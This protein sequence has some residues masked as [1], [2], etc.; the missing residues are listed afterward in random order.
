MVTSSGVLRV[1][2]QAIDNALAE[3]LDETNYEYVERTPFTESDGD[4]F[5]SANRNLPSQERR[6]K[7]KSRARR[8]A[9]LLEAAKRRDNAGG[10][11]SDEV[12][13]NASSE[14]YD[15]EDERKNRRHAVNIFDQ[16]SCSDNNRRSPQF[17]KK[18]KK[19]MLFDQ[20]EFL[21]LIKK[22]R[23]SPKSKNGVGEQ[24]HVK[25]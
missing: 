15:S 17:K 2:V 19:K 13:G 9:K 4:E 24:K 18:P 22:K 11:E 6:M 21:D 25:F 10:R 3:V 23:E 5:E 16:D 7:Q 12:A 8:R 14:S 20:K 1:K